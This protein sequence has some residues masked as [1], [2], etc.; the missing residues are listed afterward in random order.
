MQ[1]L[2]T[3]K[4]FNCQEFDDFLIEE[5]YLENV[6]VKGSEIWFRYLCFCW[7]LRLWR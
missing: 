4:Y 5:V 7:F 2:E 3:K 1:S 6:L